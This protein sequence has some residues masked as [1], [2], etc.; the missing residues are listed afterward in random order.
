MG[1]LFGASIGEE[2]GSVILGEGLAKPGGEDGGGWE[3]G[4]GEGFKGIRDGVVDG[5]GCGSGLAGE[6]GLG[7][8]RGSGFTKD[9]I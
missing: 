6:S 4:T 8:T 5:S 7:G 9:K 2:A 3:V 1:S